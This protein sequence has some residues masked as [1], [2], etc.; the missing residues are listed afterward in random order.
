MVLTDLSAP[1]LPATRKRKGS[2]SR[3][4]TMTRDL[5]SNC[6]VASRSRLCTIPEEE[7][8]RF[9]QCPTYCCPIPCGTSDSPSALLAPTYKSS[10]R[11]ATRAAVVDDHGASFEVLT[12]EWDVRADMI[13]LLAIEGQ[14]YPGRLHMQNAVRRILIDSVSASAKDKQHKLLSVAINF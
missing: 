7:V 13:D 1:S 6:P 12:W 8:I 10:L 9:P 2:R 11:P 4:A 3:A 14:T 5:M